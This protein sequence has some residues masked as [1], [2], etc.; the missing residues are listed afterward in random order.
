MLFG[1]LQCIVCLQSDEK[2]VLT[3]L[4]EGMKE[5]VSL[6]DVLPPKGQVG[7]VV[8][9]LLASTQFFNWSVS[10]QIQDQLLQII[11]I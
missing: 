8:L 11:D 10:V 7:D 5:H 9:Q 4:L 2:C 3:A 6:E 1:T